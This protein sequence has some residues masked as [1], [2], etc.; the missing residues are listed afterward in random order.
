M[1]GLMT[2]KIPTPNLKKKNLNQTQTLKPT[3]NYQPPNLKP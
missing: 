3:R 1:V 2:W